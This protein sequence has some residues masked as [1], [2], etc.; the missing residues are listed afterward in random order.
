MS[1]LFKALTPVGTFAPK[2]RDSSKTRCCSPQFPKNRLKFRRIWVRGRF[3]SDSTHLK[4]SIRSPT[5]V[6]QSI[7]IKAAQLLRLEVDSWANNARISKPNSRPRSNNLVVPDRQRKTNIL[8]FA[9]RDLWRMGPVL[10]VARC[11]RQQLE[12]V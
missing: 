11:G 8:L 10:C 5:G 2:L 6:H 4:Q 1:L 7:L 3:D 12:K 9:A